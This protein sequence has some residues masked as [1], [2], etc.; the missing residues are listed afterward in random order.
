MID[1]VMIKLQRNFKI[2]TVYY[3]FSYN[4]D[5]RKSND[6]QYQKQLQEQTKRKTNVS[7]GIV[8]VPIN[9]FR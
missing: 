1:D 6:S 2:I 5:Y 4:A 9:C 8:F 3:T 7:V